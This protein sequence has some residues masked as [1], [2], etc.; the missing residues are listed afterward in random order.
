MDSDGP[1]M[2]RYLKISSSGK[3]IGVLCQNIEEASVFEA[4][5]SSQALKV[6]VCSV[7]RSSSFTA[8]SYEIYREKVM[9]LLLKST[10]APV[11]GSPSEFNL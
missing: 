7:A 2:R 1:D 5:I 4:D 3:A 10:P 11:P 6:Q 8:L 9:I